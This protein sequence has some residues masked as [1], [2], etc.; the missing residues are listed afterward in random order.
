MDLTVQYSQEHA[1]FSIDDSDN[2]DDAEISF[3]SF[4]ASIVGIRYYSGRVS[5]NEMV[6]LRREP[7]N[8]Y[9]RNAIRV[10][11][12]FGQQVGHIKREQAEVLA[13]LV[14]KNYAKLE[15]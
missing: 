13:T 1:S 11:N 15:G 8:K 9:D 4:R 3:G 7:R 2:E 10:D 12:I 14:D 6:A 5:N